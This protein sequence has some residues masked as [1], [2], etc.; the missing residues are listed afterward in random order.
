M[1]NTLNPTPIPDEPEQGAFLRPEE[2][3]DEQGMTKEAWAYFYS[4]TF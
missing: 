3:V 4:M 1:T 2:E